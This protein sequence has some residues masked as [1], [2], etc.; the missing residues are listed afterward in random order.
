MFLSPPS[1]TRREAD[2]R[3]S[4]AQR[5]MPSFLTIHVPIDASWICWELDVDPTLDVRLKKNAHET[6]NTMSVH[7]RPVGRA[8]RLTC[9]LAV[10]STGVSI[11]ARITRD[12]L[13]LHQPASHHDRSY[14]REVRDHYDPQ[15]PCFASTGTLRL[16]FGG[17]LR[18]FFKKIHYFIIIIIISK[19]LQKILLK[20]F[21]KHVSKTNEKKKFS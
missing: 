9:C 7:L 5:I 14:V 2:L 3:Q 1:H 6:P 17:V 11:I 4:P 13:L 21:N 20:N 8:V 12:E 16:V 19:K 18:C 15:P 10:K